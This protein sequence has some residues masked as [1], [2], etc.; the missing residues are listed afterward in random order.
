[1]EKFNNNNLIIIF[2]VLINNIKNLE[3]KEYALSLIEIE[4]INV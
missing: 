2:I 1:M 4:K 3:S